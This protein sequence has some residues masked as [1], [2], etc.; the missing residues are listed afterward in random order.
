MAM[1]HSMS[2]DDI[3]AYGKQCTCTL[4]WNVRHLITQLQLCRRGCRAGA[5]YWERQLRQ[6][7]TVT[8]MTSVSSTTHAANACVIPT[9]IGYCRQKRNLNKRCEE[10]APVLKLIRRFN[11]PNNKTDQ[12]T[13]ETAEYIPSLYLLNAVA[14]SK[15]HAI[16]QITADFKGYKTAIAVITESH[17]KDKHTDSAVEITGYDVFRRDRKKRRG[18]GVAMYVS[19]SQQATIWRPSADDSMFELLWIRISS[20]FIGALYHPPKPLYQTEPT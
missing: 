12:S 11:A 4:D 17:F 15:P 10:R 5:R 16:E 6:L 20:M 14:L 9:V 18:G 1:S 8:S 19:S 2:R 7:G 13:L 3:L